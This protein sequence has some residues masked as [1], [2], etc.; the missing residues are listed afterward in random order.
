MERIELHFPASD[1]LPA[2]A[3]AGVVGSG[4]L[5]AIFQPAG[6]GKLQV[7]IRSSVDGG[8]QRW[9]HLFDRINAARPLPAGR[10]DINDFGAT[11]GVARLRIEQVFEEASHV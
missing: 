9:Q 1:T 2:K 3:L 4:D 5:E 8:H 11:P 7:I 10:L 6:G